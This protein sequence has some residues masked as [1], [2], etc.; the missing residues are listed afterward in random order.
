MGA[1]FFRALELRPTRIPVLC[2]R[3]LAVHACL[4]KN[5]GWPAGISHRKNVYRPSFLEHGFLYSNVVVM[6]S[7]VRDLY[8]RFIVVGRYY[9]AGLEHVRTR[10]KAAF[11]KN[12]DVEDELEVSSNRTEL[13]KT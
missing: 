3:V 5:A 10:V 2:C 9:P 8:K 7:L 6:N 13:Y 4:N 12:Q 11:F 1:I